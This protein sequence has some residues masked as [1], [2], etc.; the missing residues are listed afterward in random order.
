MT[1]VRMTDLDLSG[2]R[3]RIRQGEPVCADC[4]QAVRAASAR[5]WM[6]GPVYALAHP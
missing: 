2:Q 5:P 6:A 4:R 3:V 1:I